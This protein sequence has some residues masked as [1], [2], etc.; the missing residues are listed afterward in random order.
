[1]NWE[2]QRG[3]KN[4]KAKQNRYTM[5]QQRQE[6]IQ[7]QQVMNRSHNCR[8]WRQHIPSIVRS[9]IGSFITLGLVT[10]L[11]F[12]WSLFHVAWLP[13][14]VIALI[15][16]FVFVC[17][18]ALICAIRLPHCT[19]N[20]KETESAL[21]KVSSI[22]QLT[23]ENLHVVVDLVY[24]MLIHHPPTKEGKA[25]WSCASL[26]E[27]EESV[28]DDSWILIDRPDIVNEDFAI[29]RLAEVVEVNVDRGVRYYVLGNKIPS[30][31][32]AHPN[33][34]TVTDT[35][36]NVLVSNIG[37]V[38]YV[39]KKGNGHLDDPDYHSYT[40]PANIEVRLKNPD[41]TAVSGD[42]LIR[43][44]VVIPFPLDQ[45][46][47]KHAFFGLPLTNRDIASLARK[48]IELKKTQ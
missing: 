18:F 35:E 9:V 43:G 40:I 20:A 21:N 46:Q 6:V 13:Y 16:F 22:Q 2:K 25:I 14:T 36:K 12:V 1:M 48:M 4:N 19:E 3:K 34:D 38:L 30:S 44:F 5:Q 39:K 37:V 10:I 11:T 7:D 24:R 47:N 23:S 8:H 17:S 45:E 27:Y 31:W 41:T 29:P 42:L 32:S 33:I 26:M 15:V 28:P